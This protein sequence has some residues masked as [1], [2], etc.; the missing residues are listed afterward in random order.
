VV[1]HEAVTVEVSEV[2]GGVVAVGGE[3]LL[4]AA[5]AHAALTGRCGCDPPGR[6]NMAQ[7]G[8]FRRLGVKFI[9][10]AMPAKLLDGDQ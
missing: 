8:E 6:P 9:K 10:I 3:Q 4:A 5:P 2:A 1:E 7:C